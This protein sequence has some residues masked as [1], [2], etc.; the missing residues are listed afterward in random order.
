MPN[1]IHKLMQIAAVLA[2]SLTAGAAVAATVPF[3]DYHWAADTFQVG[4]PVLVDEFVDPHDQTRAVGEQLALTFPESRKVDEFMDPT[5][6]ESIERRWMGSSDYVLGLRGT[7]PNDGNVVRS[8]AIGG[9]ANTSP[10]VA[11]IP[12]HRLEPDKMHGVMWVQADVFPGDPD[13]DS[14][15][16]GSADRDSDGRKPHVSIAM[17]DDISN[18]SV[19]GQHLNTGLGELWVD[20][21]RGGH[22]TLL[23]AGNKIIADA[24]YPEFMLAP[25]L[26]NFDSNPNNDWDFLG[27]NTLFLSWDRETNT[28]SVKINGETFVDAVPLVEYSTD[29]TGLPIDFDPSPS[30]SSN[31]PDVFGFGVQFQY[32]EL[33][34]FA[35]TPEPSGMLMMCFSMIFFGWHN[36]RQRRRARKLGGMG[37]TLTS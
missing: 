1:S 9:L 22:W 10:A 12:A 28:V 25:D 2:C 34:N 7:N 21:N 23:G 31:R 3:D 5:S 14:D 29:S 30:S 4:T 36:R 33:D 35:A 11:Y 15:N 19:E 16:N 27:Y 17:L 6:I 32:G 24:D 37:L 20:I 13:I 8:N 18:Y 26:L